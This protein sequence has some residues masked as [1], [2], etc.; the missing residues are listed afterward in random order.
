M[1]GGLILLV[2]LIYSWVAIAEFVKGNFGMTIVFAGYAFSNIGLAWM[3]SKGQYETHY[4]QLDI[5]CLVCYNWCILTGGIDSYFIICR[6]YLSN[7]GVNMKDRFDLE[8]AIMGMLVIEK[9]IDT[10][11]WRI[12]DSPDGPLNEDDLANYL[13]AIKNIL[14]LRGE[15]L[16]DT[17][18]QAHK[19]D[20]YNEF[21][22]E[23]YNEE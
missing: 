23:F 15:A 22:K 3:A 8:D 20:N 10:L 2:M 11:L 21:L 17:F 18:C 12:M 13:L 6:Y 7:M 4:K 1:S 19:L 16:W 9:D 5:F 14:R